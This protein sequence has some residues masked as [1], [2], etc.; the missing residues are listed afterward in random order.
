MIVIGP[1]AAAGAEDFLNRRNPIVIRDVIAY[2]E[3]SAAGVG[4]DQYRDAETIA[5]ELWSMFHRRKAQLTVSG[6][7]VRDIS[8]RGPFA[9]PTED[10]RHAAFG[11]SLTFR[12]SEQ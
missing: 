7:H 9:A 5:F 4:P 3:N 8:V 11:V 1:N 6:F 2:A 12:L 10:D